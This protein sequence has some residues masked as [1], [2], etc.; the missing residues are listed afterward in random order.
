MCEIDA[1]F[2]TNYGKREMPQNPN[3]WTSAASSS[4]RLGTLL[5]F[6][7]VASSYPESPVPPN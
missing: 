1:W 7:M 6:E 3:A 2:C 5:L 4:I